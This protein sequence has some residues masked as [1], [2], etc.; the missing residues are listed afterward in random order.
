MFKLLFF[1]IITIQ[2]YSDHRYASCDPSL[3]P[4]LHE[5]PSLSKAPRSSSTLDNI[6][7]SK[8]ALLGIGFFN[9]VLW[10][11]F[12]PINSLTCLKLSS[13]LSQRKSFPV[14]GPVSVLPFFY[15][16]YFAL[17]VENAEDFLIF[18][19]EN[20]ACEFLKL[21]IRYYGTQTL[22]KTGP[23][24]AL[25]F[26]YHILRIPSILPLSFVLQL[27]LNLSCFLN[28][29]PPVWVSFLKILLSNDIELNPGDFQNNFFSFCNWNINSLAKENFHRAKLIEAHNSLY[30]YD[31]IYLC[32]VSLNNTVEIPEDLLNN[33]TFLARNNDAKTWLNR[34]VL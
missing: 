20:N 17:F 19:L 31:L 29:D 12:F 4:I 22:R 21:P 33:Y 15:T 10:I 5:H 6:D 9:I 25:I 13:F 3:R 30:L 27:M 28:S 24:T 23:F 7:F 8:F 2:L 16:L 1:L 34:S 11:L 26:F 32:E 18:I 14:Y